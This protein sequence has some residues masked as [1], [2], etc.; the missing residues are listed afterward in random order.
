MF[1][2]H[3]VNHPNQSFAARVISYIEDGARIG[4]SGLRSPRV[5]KNWPSAIAHQQAVTSV[6]LDDVRRGRKLGPFTRPPFDTYVGS[7]M[8]AIPKKLSDQVRI[9]HDLSFPPGNSINSHIPDSLCTVR[10]MSLD[11]ALARVHASGPGTLMAK[12]DLKD[13]YKHVGVHP[14]DWDLLGLT[15]SDQAG[16]SYYLDVTLPFGLASAPRIFTEV[17]DAL[18]FIMTQSGVSYCDHYLDDFFTLG[19]PNSHEC[20]SNMDLMLR[21]CEDTGFEVSSSPSKVVRPT[22]CLEFLGLVIDSEA[23]EVRI[24][25]ARREDLMAELTTFLALTRVRKRD[26]LSIIGKL[27]FAS[28]VVRA[29]RTF[30]RGLIHASKATRHL[31]HHVHLPRAS[32]LDLQWWLT[33]LPTWN[34]VALIPDPVSVSDIHLELA[35]D[36]SL[37]GLGAVMGADWWAINI[38][39]EL[40][41]LVGRPIA[42][43]ELYAVVTA[44]ATFASRIRGKT[45]L[46]HCDNQNVVAAVNNGVS[47]DP[48]L[49]SLV[50]ALFYVCAHNS[51]V[52]TCVYIASRD[53]VAADALSRLDFDAFHRACPRAARFP[54]PP[55]PIAEVVALC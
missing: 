26:L 23:M 45:V 50:R 44:F 35:T 7:P 41:Q 30:L 22:T 21:A 27:T 17:A 53:N 9:V 54:T 25:E 6:I 43:L 13:A 46:L 48:E 28:R 34:G 4:Y 40:P 15:L 1:R 37:Y 16:T 36:A 39:T 47:R 5:R 49:M 10:Y 42:Y 38:A 19:P 2:R 33:F 18:A 31:H 8:G 55:V 32:K 11:D 51:L 29:G 52:V 14:D 12:L 24:S 20:A 3:L